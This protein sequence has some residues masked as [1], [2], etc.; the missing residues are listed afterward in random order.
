MSISVSIAFVV[1]IVKAFVIFV[2]CVAWVGNGAWAHG[3][4][5]GGKRAIAALRLNWGKRKRAELLL[6]AP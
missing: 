6:D 4:G 5:S 1:V 3:R 2:A